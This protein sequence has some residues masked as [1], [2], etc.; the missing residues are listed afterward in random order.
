MTYKELKNKIK[1]EQKDLALKI[2]RGKYL[3]KPAHRVNISDEDK[4]LYYSYGDFA[5]WNVERLSQKYRHKH[6]VY[7]N[8]FN[9]TPYDKIEQ[10]RDNNPLSSNELEKYKKEWT[11]LL[12]EALRDSA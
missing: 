1:E 6:V 4:K 10:P 9:N 3:R 7:C 8:M 12:D 2:R 5:N 11:G